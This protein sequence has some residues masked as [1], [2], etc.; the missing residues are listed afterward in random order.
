MPDRKKSSRGQSCFL[1]GLRKVF[2]LNIGTVMFGVLLMYMIFSMV[3]YMTSTHIE[4]Y[5]VTSGPL[6]RNETYT[7]LAIREES[8]FTASSG[9]YITYYAREGN[10]VSA[11]GAVYSLS[12]VKSADTEVTL[13]HEAL[14]GIKED[15]LSLS[16]GFSS[17]NFNTIYS[18]KYDLS[19]SILQYATEDSDSTTTVSGQS[20]SRAQM[21]GVVLYSVDG[22]EDKTVDSLTEGDFNQNSYQETDLKTDEQVQTGDEVYKL[23]T[24]ETWSLL[25]P[26]SDKQAVKLSDLTTVKV[27]FSRDNATQSGSFSILEIDGSKYGKID[28]SRGVIRYASERFLDIE[29]VAN[30]V[31]GLKIPQTSIVEKECYLIPSDYVTTDDEGNRCFLVTSKNRNGETVNTYVSTTIYAT[32]EEETAATSGDTEAESTY[33]YYVDRDDFSEGDAIL[34][35]D[36][37]EKYVIGASDTIQ[38]VYCINQGYAVFCRIEILDQNEEYAIV[39]SSTSSGISRYD[40]IVSNANE[41]DEEDILY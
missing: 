34:N 23:V 1:S 8:V 17:S 30:T 28:F 15:M 7:G 12:T 10:K 37:G 26:L 22:Y 18:F 38:G 5:Q 2:G 4:S 29:L 20:I 11:N 9:G 19:G 13:D 14:S 27:K 25:I 35:S 36:T 39:S 40:R 6:S 21:S 24:S 41:L 16:K 3:V 31:T 32:I 33:I